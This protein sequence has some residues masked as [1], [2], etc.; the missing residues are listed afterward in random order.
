M[1]PLS[2]LL[3]A[4]CLL[5]ICAA[6]SGQASPPATAGSLIENIIKH[7]GA[8][9]I[10]N[11][12]DVIKTGDPQTVVSGVVTCMFAS[13]N[14][15]KKAVEMNCNLIITHEPLFYNHRD[16]TKQFSNDPVYLA[17]RKYIDDHKLVVWR[18]HDY[19]HSIK[20][21]AIDYGMI[22]KI[23]WLK[24]SSE[25]E[26]IKITLPETTVYGVIQHLKKV[27]TGYSFNVIGDPGMKVSNVMFSAGAPGSETHFRMLRRDDIDLVIAGEVPQWETYEYVR[28]AVNQGKKKA[29]IFLGHIPSEEGGMEYAAEWI[30]GFIKDTPV[31]FVECGP[32]YS[33]YQ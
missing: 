29:I 27:F 33:T 8:R 18:F 4:F 26:L 2:T 14:V 19:V 22:K 9:T 20:P 12:V 16:E 31:T 6:V 28:D 23:G 17:K 30:K 13:M 7:T 3:T 25:E 24:Y 10:P 1:K 5:T 15:L 21:D 32:S 11:T